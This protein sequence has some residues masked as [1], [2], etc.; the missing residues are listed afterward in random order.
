[1]NKCK[2]IICLASSR[3]GLQICYQK[4]VLQ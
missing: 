2:S 4:Y 1:M 3:V